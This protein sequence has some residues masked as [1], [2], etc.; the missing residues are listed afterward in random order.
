M[1]KGLKDLRIERGITL[2]E[3]ASLSSLSKLYLY[4]LEN[5]LIKDP[6]IDDIGQIAL[7]L[8]CNIADVCL[9]LLGNLEAK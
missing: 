6:T 5:G 7:A 9:A 1:N 8:E 4:N 3:L 2:D